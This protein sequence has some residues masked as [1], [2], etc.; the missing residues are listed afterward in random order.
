MGRLKHIP[1]N[2]KV[3][4]KEMEV[5]DEEVVKTKKEQK[6]SI[7][8]TLKSLKGNIEKL[9][10]NKIITKE[11]TEVITKVYITAIQRWIGTQFNL[12]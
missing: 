12:K 10:D 6:V 1:I 5:K 8:Y 11:E 4:T 3:K 9:R 7:S 2:D